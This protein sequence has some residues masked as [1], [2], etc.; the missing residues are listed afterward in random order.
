MLKIVFGNIVDN[1]ISN[2]CFWARTKAA[3]EDLSDIL[4]DRMCA[5]LA[6]PYSF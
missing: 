6:C 5:F 1:K 4:N 3:V 2:V